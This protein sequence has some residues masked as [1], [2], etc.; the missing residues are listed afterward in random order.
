[1]IEE[2]ERDIANL[3][4]EMEDTIDEIEDKWAEVATQ[5]DEITVNPYKK[6]ILVELFGVAWMPYHLVEVDRQMVELPGFAA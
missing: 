1:M 6:D 2:I 5:V 4:I 3:T